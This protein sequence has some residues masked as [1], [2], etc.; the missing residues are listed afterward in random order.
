MTN[1]PKFIMLVG[2]PGSGKSTWVDDFV[3]DSPKKWIVIGT[4]IFVNKH[5]E[6]NGLT[7]NEAFAVL[8]FKK[9]HSKFNMLLRQSV[10]KKLNIII[11][12][13]NMSIG[14]RRKILSKIHSE[15]E[16]AV[17]VFEIDR[18]ELRRRGDIR[19]EETGK[20]VP[21]ETIDIM[22]SRYKRPTKKEGFNNVRIINK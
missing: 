17:I 9:I 13:T 1:D 19:K 6:E 10:N 11:D 3:F 5:A 16:T 20:V 8:S 2:A 12:R 18:D 22:I 4:D 21:E 14:A 15:Y 7:Y